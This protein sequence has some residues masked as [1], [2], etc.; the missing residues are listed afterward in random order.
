[1]RQIALALSSLYADEEFAGPQPFDALVD[2]TALEGASLYCSDDAAAAV[3]DAISALPARA[4]HWID[5]GDYHYLSLFWLEKIDEPFTLVLFDNHPDDQPTAFDPGA[6]SCGSWVAAARSSLPLMKRDVWV[7][8]AADLEALL[9]NCLAGTAG[10]PCPEDD[11]ETVAAL[12]IY[13]SIDLDVLS[14]TEFST[15]WDQGDMTFRELC[16]AISRLAARHRIIGIDVCGGITESKGATG[17]QLARNAALREALLS[18]L[19]ALL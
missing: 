5:T 18:F 9:G 2:L 13:L 10:G 3:R 7:R 14:P 19:G 8:H 4:V 11:F 1:M 12:P 6:L 17:A 16:S 15:D